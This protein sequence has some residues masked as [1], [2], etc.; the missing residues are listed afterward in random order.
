M[1]DK[2]SRLV[3]SEKCIIGIG[4]PLSALAIVIGR[5]GVSLLKMIFSL[6]VSTKRRLLQK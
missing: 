6:H 5:L 3:N 2:P 4:V 1:S